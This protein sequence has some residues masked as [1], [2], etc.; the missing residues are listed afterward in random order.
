VRAVFGPSNTIIF[1]VIDTGIGIAPEDRAKIFDE[2]AQVQRQAGRRQRDGSGLGLAIARRIVE[3]H[4]GT[5]E[6]TSQLGQGSTFYFTI[7]T[8]VRERSATSAVSA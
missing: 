8:R 6:V 5:L 2:F 7:P 4:E 1:S 3:A